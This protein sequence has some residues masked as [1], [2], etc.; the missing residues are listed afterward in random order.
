MNDPNQ[1]KPPVGK[2]VIVD[3]AP[4][5]LEI[6]SKLLQFEGFHVLT[7]ASGEEGVQKVEETHPEVVLMDISLPGIDGTEALR[8]I[9][10]THPLT[11]VIMLTAYATV[12]NAIRALKEG[13]ADFVRK[14]FE[15]DHLIHIVHQVCPSPMI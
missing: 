7:A 13:A 2:V 6:I 10:Q 14:P 1:P 3:D 15:N 5:T 11:I 9:K 12:E 4:D 8:R